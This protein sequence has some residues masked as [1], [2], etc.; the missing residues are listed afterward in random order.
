VYI[1]N[2][3]GGVQSVTEEHYARYLT[4][5]TNDGGTYPIP[6]VSILTEDEAR[7]ANPQL[8]GHLDPKVIFTDDEL[9]RQLTRKKQLRELYEEDAA[10]NAAKRKG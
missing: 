2:E 10:A 5:R 1:R 3:M 8:F 4:T 9:A 6:G 7:E